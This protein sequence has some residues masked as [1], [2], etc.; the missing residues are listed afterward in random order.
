MKEKWYNLEPILA[1]ESDYHVIFG[2][3]SNGKTYS[4]LKYMIKRYIKHGIKGAYVRRWRDD[5]IG[6]RGASIFDALVADNKIYE[7]T[8]GEWTDVYYFSG[9]WYLCRYNEKNER[10]ME[11]KPFCYGFALTTMEHD[12]STSFPEVGTILFDEYLTRNGYLPDEFVL[13]TN[14]ISTIIRHK[15]HVFGQPIKIFMCGNTVN[16]YACPYYSEMGLTH[17]KDMKHGDIDV[18]NYGDSGLKVAVEYCKPNKNGKPSDKFFAFDNPKLKMIT[19]GAWEIGIYPHCP[20]KIRPKDIIFKYY[21]VFDSEILECQVVRNEEMFFTFIHRKTTPLE[22]LSTDL[23][24][25][26]EFDAR[27]NFRRKI[28][29]P[30]SDLEKRISEFYI[31]DKIFYDCNDT[32]EIIRN[33]LIWC[34]KDGI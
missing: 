8:N 2:E 32:G 20:C 19:G 3:R 6:Q 21:I 9:R 29:K 14:V 18:Y 31:K 28:T 33:Y 5:F 13:F 30:R 1:T 27:P 4:V 25:S 16:K 10:I 26:T 34:G 15:T 17:V 7:I 23:I 11:E 12:K 24:Y 22:E